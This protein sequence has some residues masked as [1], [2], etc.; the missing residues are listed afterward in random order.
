[1]RKACNVADMEKAFT[2]ILNIESTRC[3]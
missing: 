3:L 1:M 2:I